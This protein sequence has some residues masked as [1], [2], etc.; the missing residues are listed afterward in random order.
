MSLR[1]ALLEESALQEQALSD[2]TI[3]ESDKLLEELLAEATGVAGDSDKPRIPGY[4][5][6]QVST[7]AESF[8]TYNQNHLA[9]LGRDDLSNLSPD[10]TEYYNRQGLHGVVVKPSGVGG[11]AIASDLLEDDSSSHKNPNT[12]MK[13]YHDIGG[14][15]IDDENDIR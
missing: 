6:P 7:D 9:G 8:Q 12:D 5:A 11:R 14:E 13:N 3:T 10:N 15:D 2:P 4:D 1:D